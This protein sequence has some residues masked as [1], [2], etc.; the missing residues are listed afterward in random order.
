MSLE[1]GLG[2]QSPSDLQAQKTF[3][4]WVRGFVKGT[5]ERAALE[6]GQ[7][8]AVIDPATGSAVLLPDAQAAVDGSGRLALSVL[9]A[10]PGEVCVL[11]SAGMV[12]MTNRAWRAFGTVRAGAGLGV[13]LGAN[14]LAACTNAPQTERVHAMALAA[15]LRQVLAGVRSLFRCAYVCEWAGEQSAFTMTI[16]GIVRD[17][18]V[19]AIVAR[20]SDERKRTGTSRAS[21]RTQA[22]RKA[23]A[24][25]AMTANRMLAALPATEYERLLAEAEP[26][27]LTY[28]EV[29]YE[30]GEQMRHVYFPCDSLV[31][32]LTV[33]EGHRAL[34]VGLVGREGMLGSRLALG[35]ASASAR[36][37]VQATGKAWRI[38]SAHFLLRLRRSP[39][40]QRALLRFTDGLMTQVS[41]TAACNRFHVVEARLARWLLMT[42]E[43]LPS[44]EFYLTHE[45]LADMLGVR[46]VGVTA[47]AG[48]LQ[49][50][51][52]IR[53]R[54]GNIRILDQRGL[55]AASCSCYSRVQ[56]MALEAVK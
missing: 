10:L 50:R 1:P 6:A 30:P 28:G 27:Q 47:A 22:A 4:D 31:S 35:C 8:D 52:L 33:V 16:T 20:A 19:H 29:L 2:A 51:G 23:E 48:A 43:R 44:D 37:L 46:R 25:R 55:E 17:G 24:T 32:L 12:V 49:R 45:F 36:A 9:D 54:R 40:L 53:Y 56:V 7:I 3:M 38:E 11:D 21:G 34:E 14:F 26:V 15:G 41:Q 39:A 18:A 13:C 5:A 42:R